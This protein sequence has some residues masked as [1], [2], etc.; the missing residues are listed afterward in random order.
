MLIVKLKF[1]ESDM[2]DICTINT[3][4][5]ITSHFGNPIHVCMQQQVNLA[6]E[7]FF[8]VFQVSNLILSFFFFEK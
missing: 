7:R 4:L 1:V 8:A 2:N 6:C 3:F 5:M